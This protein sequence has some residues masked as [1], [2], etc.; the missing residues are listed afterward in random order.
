V[1]DACSPAWVRR[2]GPCARCGRRLT[3]AWLIAD[4]PTCGRCRAVLEPAWVVASP[5]T[6]TQVLP[7][8]D[9]DQLELE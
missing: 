6:A 2:P 9:P 3:Y 4:Q 8:P 5:R 1:A 7:D